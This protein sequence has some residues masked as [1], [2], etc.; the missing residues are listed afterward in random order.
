MGFDP[1]SRFGEGQQTTRV[2]LLAIILL[3]LPCYCLG[4]I[5]LATAPDDGG[6]SRADRTRPPTL[7]GATSSQAVTPSI[8][9]FFTATHYAADD[10][11]VCV[12]DG[13]ADSDADQH[14]Y[15][16]A[17]YCADDHPDADEHPGS[18]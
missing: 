18:D 17:D 2:V 4:A 3:T 12:P 13:Y 1:L 11:A 16:N 7:G 14:Q 9:P 15:P 10:Y 6:S 8:T 5:L